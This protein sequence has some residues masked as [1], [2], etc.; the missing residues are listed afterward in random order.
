M[1]YSLSLWFA[2]SAEAQVRRAWQ[3]L[4]GA[5][6]ETVAGGPIRPHVTLSHGLELELDPFVTALAGRL[7]AHPAFDL[8]FSSLGLF[9][10]SGILYLSTVMT[11]PLWTLHREVYGLASEYGGRSS[12]YYLTDRWT[13]HCTLALN[14]GL[15][16]MVN[17][18]AACQELPFP[19]TVLAT[20]VGIIEN[21][22]E[23]ELLTLPLSVRK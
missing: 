19:L 17:A 8:T 23:R 22:S 9:V 4:A 11:E 3:G 7:E 21:P 14:L 15:E 20:R 2:G 10:E 5:G 6:V 1:A 16:A 13:P 18:V 12:P